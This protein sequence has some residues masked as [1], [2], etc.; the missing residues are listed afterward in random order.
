M[1]QMASFLSTTPGATNG[2]AGAVHSVN[3]W[4]Y[5]VWPGPLKDGERANLLINMHDYF[6]P[7]TKGDRLVFREITT[8][9]Y[10]LGRRVRVASPR[11]VFKHL[12]R[13][14]A[15]SLCESGEF[16]LG[17]LNFYTTIENE[18]I[19]DKHE[20]LFVTYAEGFRCSI[21]SV[22]GA[23]KHVLLYCTTTNR[24]AQFGYD[25]CVEISQPEHFAQ[26]LASAVAQHFKGRNVL[27]RSEHSK[28][29]Y[30]HSRI[31]SGRMHGF[32]EALVH[33]GELSVDTIDVLSDK[34]YLIKEK[35]HAKD[36]EYRFAL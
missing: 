23:G 20:G 8:K 28:C 14:H 25:A 5:G 17:P 10:F 11:R 26:A 33:L 2:P 32:S 29:V 1:G 21:A 27:V 35:S 15:V 6:F 9:K 19:A 36:S 22:N 7:T 24:N 13:E 31:I 30:Q 4:E 34:K 18:N 12:K 3:L 16:G